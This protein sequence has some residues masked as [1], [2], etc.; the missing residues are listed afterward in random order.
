MD[1]MNLMEGLAENLKWLTEHLNQKTAKYFNL[2]QLERII[3]RLNEFGSECEA[4]QRLGAELLE[5]TDRMKASALPVSKDLFREYQRK[6]QEIIAHLSK[7][8]KLSQEGHYIGMSMGLGMCFGMTLGML[9]GDHMTIGMSIGMCLGL[10]I[11]AGLD[12]TARKKGQVI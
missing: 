8:H 11:G 3:H 1:E 2:K 7:A 9:L 12:E 6:T 4:C 10:A 5:L